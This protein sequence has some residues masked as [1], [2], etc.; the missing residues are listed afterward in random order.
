MPPDGVRIV[1]YFFHCVLRVLAGIFVGVL[2]VG[3]L[4]ASVFLTLSA[5]WLVIL[6]LALFVIF[7]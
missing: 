2:V 7:W 6:I 1:I 5:P 4:I 3:S